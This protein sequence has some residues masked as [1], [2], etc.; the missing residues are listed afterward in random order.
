MRFVGLL[1]VTTA[2]LIQDRDGARP[3]VML[4]AAPATCSLQLVDDVVAER[5]G[6]KNAGFFS[7]AYQ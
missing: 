1:D 5:Q 4:L 2:G 3:V 7:G 6:G